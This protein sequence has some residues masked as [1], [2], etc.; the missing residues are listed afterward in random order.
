MHSRAA[1]AGA[2]R[3]LLGIFWSVGRWTQDKEG[4]RGGAPLGGAD[5]VSLLPFQIILPWLTLSDKVHEQTRA[6]GTISRMLRFVCNFPELSVSAWV[7][8]QA[9]QWASPLCMALEGEGA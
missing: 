4:R 9:D 2:P 6:L 3:P 1:H 8:G 7:R 5:G